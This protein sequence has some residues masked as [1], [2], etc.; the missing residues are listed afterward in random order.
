MTG[1]IK[2]P[3]NYQPPK[4]VEELLLRYSKG[5]RYFAELELDN[6]TYDFQN[7]TLEG[8]DFSRSFI[9]ADFRGANLKRT[10]FTS[11][12]IKTCDF[13]NTDLEGADL[14]GAALESTEFAGANLQGARFVGATIYNHTMKE[15]E[16]PWW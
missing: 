16:M 9:T 15:N 8:A 10:A 11:A 2:K 4:S 7:A 12:N 14:S 6:A 1:S 5:E 13:R 3:L